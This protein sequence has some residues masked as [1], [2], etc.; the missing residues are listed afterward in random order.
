MQQRR[1]PLAS[2]RPAGSRRI[3]RSSLTRLRLAPPLA[4][5]VPVAS[6]RRHLTDGWRLRPQVLR[7]YCLWD[8]RKTVPNGERR[9]YTLNYFLA[10]DTVEVLE[11]RDPAGGRDPWV[12]LRRLRLPP[13]FVLPSCMRASQ[14]RLPSRPRA[15][16][17][18][19][20]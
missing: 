17:G 8:T 3:C 9:I 12:R 7:F 11:T 18:A 20:Q 15:H 6:R 1:R 10:D 14:L 13:A 2:P 16:P 4:F 5:R 19:T